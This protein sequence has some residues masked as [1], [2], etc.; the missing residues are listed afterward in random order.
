MTTAAESILTATSHR[1]RIRVHRVIDMPVHDETTILT[2]HVVSPMFNH[3]LQ[4]THSATGKFLKDNKM[5]A[6]DEF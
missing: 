5:Y 1:A 6:E 3:V 2:H 4:A